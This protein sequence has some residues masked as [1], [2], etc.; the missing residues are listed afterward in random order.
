MRS[1]L[2]LACAALASCS[3]YDTRYRFEPMPVESDVVTADNS[4]VLARGLV[5]VVGLRKADE[6]AGLPASMELRLHAENPG[7]APFILEAGAARLYTADLKPFPA[8][9]VDPQ[10]DPE[11][12]GGAAASVT[13]YFPLPDGSSA[14]DLNLGGLS[15]RWSVRRGPDSTATNATFTRATPVYPQFEGYTLGAYNYWWWND[16]WFCPP[17]LVPCRV[18][19]SRR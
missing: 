2:L 5:S 3:A 16:P 13:L 9:A 15:L 19:S 11:V 6:E 14:S 18:P 12:A 17:P 7:S 8:P 10:G 1:A 4:A